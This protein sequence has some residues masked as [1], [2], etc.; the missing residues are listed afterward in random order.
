MITTIPARGS[1]ELRPHTPTGSG[2][3]RKAKR[4]ETGVSHVHSVQ[5]SPTDT[6][7]GHTRRQTKRESTCGNSPAPRPNST[8]KLTSRSS[9]D[10]RPL[11]PLHQTIYKEYFPPEPSLISPDTKAAGLGDSTPRTSSRSPELA[12]ACHGPRPTHRR[13]GRPPAQCWHACSPSG[14]PHSWWSSPS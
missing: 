2:R 14:S 7:H 5:Y 10:F 9:H 13:R 6:A 3:R 12:R 11:I 8:T 1:S 4:E